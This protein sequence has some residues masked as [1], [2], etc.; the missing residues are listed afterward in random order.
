MK[1][2][3][4]ATVLGFAVLAL[5]ACAGPETKSTAAYTLSVNVVPSYSG[6]VV[7]QEPEPDS[8]AQYPDGT[9][10]TLTAGPSLRHECKDTPYWAFIGW[11]ADVT[12]STPTAEIIIT[13][14]KSVTAGFKEFFP[15]ECP[16]PLG[17]INLN[18]SGGRGPFTFEP[19]DLTFS[20]GETVTLELRSETQF[21]TFTVGDLDI[22]VE[23]DG[24]TT[25][26]FP[27]TFDKP[28]TFKLIC[29]PHEG[30]GMTGTITVKP[31]PQ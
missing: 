1:S 23:V 4:I 21:H 25:E 10:V 30:L 7:A 22:D 24:G 2:L 29:I 15:P 18:D 5:A 26:T 27:F 3:L 14:D 28:G 11:S 6:G 13:S 9:V 16:T 12:G 17:V 8:Q 31:T 20:V 19:A